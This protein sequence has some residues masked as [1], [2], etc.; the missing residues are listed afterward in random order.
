ME[1]LEQILTGT[2]P[3]G[4]GNTRTVPD[5]IDF[6]PYPWH[7]M[8]IWILTQMKR[9]GYIKGDVNYRKIA[10]EV[11]LTSSC[12]EVMQAMGHKA[13]KDN[14]KTHRF[15]DG[16]VFDPERPEDYVNSFAIRRT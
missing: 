13:P 12:R 2:F 3:D 7:S 6:D 8:A 14:M 16:K 1:V 10:E 4:L 5:R 11:Y 15:A 9:W